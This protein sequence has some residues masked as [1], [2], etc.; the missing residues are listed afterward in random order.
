M[1]TSYSKCMHLK[2]V[3]KKVY[4]YATYQSGK[5]TDASA[6]ISRRRVVAGGT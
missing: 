4:I 3:R 1:T 6:K 5:S 2:K